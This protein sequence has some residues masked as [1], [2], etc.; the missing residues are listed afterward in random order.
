MENHVCRSEYQ[1]VIDF[2]ASV[3]GQDG[4]AEQQFDGVGFAGNLKVYGKQFLIQ[5]V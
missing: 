3:P 4:V 2:L 1:R 5:I